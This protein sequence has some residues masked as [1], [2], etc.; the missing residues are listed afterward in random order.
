MTQRSLLRNLLAWTLAALALVWASFIAVGFRT[1]IQEADELTD[2]HLASVALLL[3]SE[4]NGEFV[5]KRN[6]AVAVSPDLKRHDYQPSMSVVV[7]DGKGRVL[8]HTGEAPVPA[9]ESA[10]GFAD[11]RHHGGPSRSGTVRTA[12]ARSWCC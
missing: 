7:W 6:L 11:L 10:Q 3:L 4:R 12:L 5:E 8:T 9:F 2:G 1:G